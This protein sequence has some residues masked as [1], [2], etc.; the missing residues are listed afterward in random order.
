MRYYLLVSHGT[1]ASGMAEALRMLVGTPEHLIVHEMRD[2]LGADAYIETLRE[3]VSPINNTDQVLLLADLAE[4]SPMTNAMRVL[5][6][7]NLLPNTLALAGMNLPMA[8]TAAM[9]PED[10][11]IKQI[12][13]EVLSESRQQIHALYLTPNEA[14]EEEI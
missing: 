6:E 7:K 12:E 14:E 4:G 2:G 8:V 10:L 3:K 1:Y 9:L 11:P 5:D 13:E